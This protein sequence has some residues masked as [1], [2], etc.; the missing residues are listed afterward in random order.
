VAMP[1][2]ASAA[3]V[4]AKYDLSP[5]TA[6]AVE[7][8]LAAEVGRL[9]DELQRLQSAYD[10]LVSPRGAPVTKRQLEFV[11]YLVEYYRAHR[12]APTFAEIAQR[13]NLKS[14]GT[15]Y[16]LLGTLEGKG[17]LKRLRYQRRAIEL[18]PPAFEEA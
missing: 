2:D 11:R 4:L 17:Y 3:S 9:G 14:L 15:I 5:A 1:D 7:R 6:S 10:R 8:R 16:E 12:C 13:F 18:L